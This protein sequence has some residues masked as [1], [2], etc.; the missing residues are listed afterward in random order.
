MNISPS[1]E[2]LALYVH[3]P[4]CQQRCAYCHF[5]I[6]VLHPRTDEHAVYR[7]YVDN[8]C[9]ELANYAE[10]DRPVTSLFYGGGTP[11]R[12]PLHYLAEIQ[13][14]ISA[15]FRLDSDCEISMEVNP[16]DA[17]QAFLE[18]ISALGVNRVSFGVQTFSD[19][20]LTA[21][22]RAH[23]AAQALAAIKRAPPFAKGRSL[24]LILGLPHGSDRVLRRD[25]DHI[26]ELELEHVALYMLETDLP[27]PLDKRT[28]LPRPDE[29]DQADF[30]LKV[31]EVLGEA[32]FRHYEISNFCQPGY[33]CRHNL[34]Y[35]RCG[36]YLGLGPAAHG[37]VALVYSRNHPSLASW[38]REVERSG[39]GIA[40]SETWS[41]ERF[42][43][44]RI[45]GG[46]RLD[47]GVPET[48]LKDSERT[49]LED[50][51]FANLVSFTEGRLGLTGQGRLLGNEV[52]QIFL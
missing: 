6:K 44:E 38:S 26:L 29:D 3:V 30:Y 17:S 2:P 31:A 8:L 36:D 28:D 14:A 43:Q 1:N 7:R 40:E 25:L 16:E 46:L 5:D 52:F 48:W 21:V 34:T 47:E 19:E 35:W 33:A 15:N 13:K 18:G 39:K 20:G 12:L 22:N 24:D 10:I 9:R 11:S 32:G 23:N 49:R 42:R 45:I 50:P 51:L 27:T 4:F 41:D 37:R